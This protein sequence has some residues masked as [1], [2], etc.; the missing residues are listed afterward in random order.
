MKKFEIKFKDLIIEARK[1]LEEMYNSKCVEILKEQVTNLP[2]LIKK[3]HHNYV[4]QIIRRKRPFVNLRL[5]FEHLNLYCWNFFEYKVLEHLIESKCS[6]DLK[7]KMG[8]YAR[9]IESF[10]QRTTITEFIKCGRHLVK[11]R[12]I[13]PRFKDITIEH[14]I[15]P[16]NYTLAELDAFRIDTLEALHLK[17]SECAFQVYRIKYGSVVVQWMIP[18]DFETPVMELF[19][20]EAGQRL[21]QKHSVERLSVDEAEIPIKKSVRTSRRIQETSL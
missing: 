13:P 17:L 10:R 1:E 15:N 12:T 14:A 8:R 20:G 5:F 7:Y 11:K 21:L 6:V 9:D 18:E 3:E 4:T 2:S 19:Y 16:D